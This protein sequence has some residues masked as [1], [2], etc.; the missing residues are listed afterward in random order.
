M[1][2]IDAAT[3]GIPLPH[4]LAVQNLRNMLQY[5]EDTLPPMIHLPI[6]SEDTLHIYRY[7]WTHIIIADK[8]FLLLIDVPIQDHAQQID[9]YEVFNLDIRP[10]NYPLHYDIED[11]YLGITL[12]E[13]SAIESLENQFQTWKRPMDNFVY[14]THHS[15]H[16]S[17]HQHIYHLSMPRTRIVSRKD[18]P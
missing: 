5:I 1:D 6:S 18:V 16:L 7:L 3:T 9:G 15:W 4:V 17:N 11:K 14:S 2:Y 13:T 8:Q 10:G 12:D